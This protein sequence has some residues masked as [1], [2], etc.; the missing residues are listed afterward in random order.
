MADSADPP[1][2]DA[3]SGGGRLTLAGVAAR[4]GVSPGTVRR[5]LAK[6]L[7][8]GF[9]GTWTPATAAYV[10]VIARLRARGHTLEEIKRASDH[11][12]LAAS[13]IED[14]LSSSEGRYTLEEIARETQLQPVLIERILTTMGLGS[15]VSMPMSDEDREMMQYVAAMLEAGLPLVAFLQ[16]ARVY[17]QALAQVAEA[18]VRL[19]HLY[20]HEPLMREGIPSV[21]VAEQMEGLARELLPFVV[22]LMSFV[23]T[24]FLA[25][26]VEQDIIGH[27]EQDLAESGSEEGRLR[28]AIAF[29]DL[30]GYARL[31]VERGDEE[32]LGAVERFQ[33]VVEQSL[34]HDAR[35]TKT[36]G[37]EVMVVATDPAA[38][39]AWAVDLQSA[40]APGEPP[41]RIGIHYGEALYRDGDYYGR[42]VNQA[43]R[44]VARAGGG[45]VLVTRPVVDMA[46]GVDGVAFERIGEVGLKGFSEPTE[47]F[48]AAQR[49]D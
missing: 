24:R 40:I 38:L 27:M 7:V 39:T 44:V 26:F 28:V 15:L 12:Q 2:A 17:G 16:L 3:A 14:L 13:P 1:S 30:A 41:P 8:P 23:H 6:G 4:A 29:A 42:E 32:A 31:T 10:R 21:E 18:E 43:A 34:P 45:E 49:E 9:D 11:G 20:V 46:S 22:P 35:V 47:L 5:W 37:D 33:D 48:T 25:Q 36:L 19:L